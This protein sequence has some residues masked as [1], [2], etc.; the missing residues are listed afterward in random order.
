[1]ILIIISV[2]ALIVGICILNFGSWRYEVLG[3]ILIVLASL[4]LLLVAITIPLNRNDYYRDA[5]SLEAFRKTV[6]QSRAVN[7]T[8]LERVSMLRS[9][10]EWNEKIAGAKYDNEHLYDLWI[11]DEVMDLKPIE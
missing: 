10:A 5:A 2:V 6:Y 3:V 9:I 11:P 1:M 8:D 7:P 4:T